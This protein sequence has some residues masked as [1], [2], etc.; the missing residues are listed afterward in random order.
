MLNTLCG[1]YRNLW[2]GSSTL[3]WP[4]AV[5][6]PEMNAKLPASSL[7]DLNHMFNGF[8]WPVARRMQPVSKFLAVLRCRMNLVLVG[9]EATHW[10]KPLVQIFVG[11]S[12]LK[13]FQR[14]FEYSPGWTQPSE[15]SKYRIILQF[16]RTVVSKNS[17]W[18]TRQVQRWNL[19][20]QIHNMT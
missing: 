11:V 1:S 5:T 14:C 18:A 8:M 20:E 12:W 15:Y 19:R 10:T 9:D 7:I 6:V 4:S 3:M 17:D 16:T 13:G 2:L